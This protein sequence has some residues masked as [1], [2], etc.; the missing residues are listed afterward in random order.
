RWRY[1]C[2]VLLAAAAWLA[3]AILNV[4]MGELNQDE[5]W[6]LY[7][8]RL[9]RAERLPYR[10]FAFTQPPM[11][12]LVYAS[13][14]P[15]MS[16]LG[17]LGGRILSALFGL[18]AALL[19]AW[20]AMRMAPH[21]NQRLAGALAFVL[22]AVN[23]HQAYFSAVVKTYSLASLFLLA[24]LVALSA[25]G[26]LHGARAA[27]FS[28]LFL[29][30]A[31]AT[32]VS[33]AVPLTL[34][35]LWLLFS[36]RCVR[37]FA[38]LDFALG[39]FLALVLFVLPFA[40]LS[41][42]GFL[43]G[44]VRY[45]AL[46]DPGPAAIQ[47][48]F[49]AGCLARLLQDY[50]PAAL[51]SAVLLAIAALRRRIARAPHLP[52]PVA[53]EAREREDLPPRLGLCLWL[54]FLGVAFVHLAAPFPYDDYQAPLYPLFAALVAVAAARA[55]VRHEAS[56]SLVAPY[57]PA[58]RTSRRSA[59]LLA[60]FS[61]CLLH[62]VA[63]PAF[64][65]AF[66]AGRDRIWWRLRTQSPVAQ[67][68]DTARWVADMTRAA[69]GTALFTQDTYLAVEADL[70]VPDGLEMGPFSYYPD[71]PTARAK[72][73]R[74]MNRPLMQTAL[75][76]L[77]NAPVV[78]LSGYGLAIASPDLVPVSDDDAALFAS[79]ISNRFDHVED[80]PAFG[81]A[82]TTLRLYRVKTAGLPQK[83]AAALLAAQRKTDP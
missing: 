14:W 55:L 18:G 71:W 7:A 29:A 62:T 75:D 36:G 4:W 34:A 77:T 9:L 16:R 8:A 52:D 2:W 5:G 11:L 19:S 30:C 38:W 26:R 64:H 60:A 27:F 58:V 68:R 76:T 13:V 81:Q 69:G 51:L 15:W 3:L 49:K 74:V 35:G 45:H 79:I 28:G 6:Y 24:G 23:A 47:L 50:F 54:S 22:V 31:A 56:S 48:A 67:L 43:F 40:L 21:R 82:A 37:P 83:E 33:L 53:V 32:R 20:L 59:I 80:I 25:V 12:P 44:V 66:V 41:P 42:R 46:R 39:T 70:D 65:S 17:L 57:P 63:S 61:L 10:D 73:L 78:A 72:R 1:L